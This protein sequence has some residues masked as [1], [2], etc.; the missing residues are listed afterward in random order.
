MF[1]HSPY[2]CLCCRAC[3]YFLWLKL[4]SEI[5]RSHVLLPGWYV[6]HFLAILHLI[7]GVM[8]LSWSSLFNLFVQI[9][10]DKAVELILDSSL[11]VCMWDWMR[12]FTSLDVKPIYSA[13]CIFARYST[14]LVLHSPSGMH[15]CRGVLGQRVA[16]FEVFFCYGYQW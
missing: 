11:N 1:G 14:A 4:F 5:Q 15:S 2:V 7:F 10:F 13:F 8:I 16:A 6:V 12:V 3:L 9:N